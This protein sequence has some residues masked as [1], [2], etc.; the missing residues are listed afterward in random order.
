MSGFMVCLCWLL[1]L[2]LCLGGCKPSS[3]PK[4]DPH[5]GMNMSA[6]PPATH[7]SG[8]VTQSPKPSTAAVA[9]RQPIMITPE[10][11]QLI[12]VKIAKVEKRQLTTTIRATGK[13][14]YN[15]KGI[16]HI[17]TKVEGWVEKLYADYTG[18]WVR[19]GQR[20]LDIYSPDLLAAQK[21]YLLALQ[22]E[23]QFAQSEWGVTKETSHSLVEAARQKLL[24]WDL[25]P[26][27][28]ARIRQTGNIHKNVTL[29]APAAGYI[30]EK[31]ALTGMQ[32][33]P[34]MELFT[35]ADL[36]TV[37]VHAQVY[38]SDIPQV[39][40]GQSVSVHLSYQPGVVFYGHV[41]Y[42]YP[43]LD[44]KSRTA[45]VRISFL[46]PQ[47][48]LKPDMYTEVT[49][50]TGAARTELTIPVDA[51]I[52]SGLRKLVFVAKA[53][54]YFEP[55]E[56][57]TGEQFGDYYVVLGG[58]WEKEQVVSSANFLMDSESQLKA[59]AGGMG[60]MGGMSH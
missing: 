1:F 26:F 4:A 13:V 38:E 2:G 18:Q 9:G 39:H 57:Q 22:A 21:E 59:V 58:L 6:T 11:Q 27:Q 7:G 45:T 23:K 51:V 25:Q 42:I 10:K 48:L 44:P 30:I 55:R 54:G 41:T 28:I 37:W 52:D 49:I 5:A 56:V 15:E 34:G 8:H 31:K 33:M 29:Y 53:G 50:A 47:G 3:P 17:H 32:V 16:F 60:G 12:G 46:N 36:R 24:L 19:K 40:L 35:L 14:E 20:L 43:Y